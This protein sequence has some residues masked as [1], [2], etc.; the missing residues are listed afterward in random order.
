MLAIMHL[1]DVGE[2]AR[3]NFSMAVVYA[4]FVCGSW[5]SVSY[6]TQK[7]MCVFPLYAVMSFFILLQRFDWPSLVHLK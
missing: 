7:G 2:F 5:N 4:I 3:V 1:L 6:I